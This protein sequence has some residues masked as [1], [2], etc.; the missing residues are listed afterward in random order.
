[1]PTLITRG[2]AS[3]RGFG[4]LESGATTRKEVFTSSGSWTCP[5]GVTSLIYLRG[6]GQDATSDYPQSILQPFTVFGIGTGT[7]PNSPFADWGTVNGDCTTNWAVVYSA[8]NTISGPTSLY[9]TNTN[10]YPDDTWGSTTSG[11]L[12]LDGYYISQ[13]S[14]ITTSGQAQSG[15]IIQYSGGTYEYGRFSYGFT[16]IMYGSAGA[17]TTGFSYTFAGGALVGSYPDQIG[18]P[19]TVT[20]YTGV[21]VTPGVT[22]NFVVAPGGYVEFAYYT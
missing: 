20:T 17:D 3:G 1:M 6:K 12:N 16:R 5:A 4:L 14:G 13:V 8:L 10:V 9:T 22:Y 7:G 18:S 19:A 15:G 2:A 11:A 21:S